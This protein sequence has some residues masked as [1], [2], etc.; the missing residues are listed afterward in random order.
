[1]KN[2]LFYIILA[3]FCL[4]ITGGVSAEDTIVYFYEDFE[5]GIGDDWSQEYV[6]GNIDWYSLNGGY[7]T[8]TS[9][10]GGGNPPFA[11]E[12]N[13]NAL[14][15]YTSLNQE[16]TRLVTPPIALD[17]AISPELHFMHAQEKLQILGEQSDKLRVLI[18]TGAEGDWHLLDEYVDPTTE[19]VFRKILIPDSLLSQ[20]NF[21][22]FEA[23]TRN[24]WGVCIDTLEIVEK[25]IRER[26]VDTVIA[27]QA[28]R[29]EVP[30]GTNNNP[31]LRIDIKVEG[32]FGDI[33]LNS[34]TINTLDTKAGNIKPGGVKLYATNKPTFSINNPLGSPQNMQQY[35]T[36]NN[37]NHTLKTGYN[38]IYVTY[39]VRD[40]AIQSDTLDAMLDYHSMDINSLMYP[41]VNHNPKG[42]RI[43]FETMFWDDFETD[44][45]WT[46]TG[47]FER[48]TAR[49][50]GGSIG[51]P[52]PET[53]YSETYVLGTDLSGLGIHEGDYEDSL[54]AYE[55]RAIS[56]VIDCGDYK[57]I[58]LR[59]R[60]WLNV[61]LSDDA[62]IDVSTHNSENWE[63][64]WI[65]NGVITDDE[66]KKIDLDISHIADRAKDIRIRFSIGP[67]DA[68]WAFSGWNIDDLFV[69]GDFVYKDIALREIITPKSGTD[70]TSS[71]QVK[72]KLE[73]IGVGDVTEN[74]SIQYILK[75]QDGNEY[76]TTEQISS[77]LN[78][79]DSLTYVFSQNL[80][81]SQP[82]YYE[83]TIIHHLSTDEYNI[84]DTLVNNI[85]VIPTMDVPYVDYFED[86]NN[87]WFVNGFEQYIK[88]EKQRSSW[89]WGKPDAFLI[90]HAA[91]DSNAW[92]TNLDGYYLQN[93]TSYIETP[94]F[95]FT[96]INNPYFEMKI[97]VST[98][99]NYDGAKLLY[100][101]DEG[102]TWKTV[103]ENASN[104]YGWDWYNDGIVS[105][106]GT[107]GWWDTTFT[108]EW[109]TVQQFLSDEIK[110]SKCKFRILFASGPEF[111]FDE[112]F[113]FDDVI[114]S[115]APPDLGVA[116]V[117]FPDDTCELSQEQTVS[118]KIKNEGIQVL[119]S[120]QTLRTGIFLQDSLYAID[121]FVTNSSVPVNGTFNYTF[122]RIFNM[123]DSGTY[124]L[125]TYVWHER[126][127]NVYGND[128]DTLTHSVNVVKPDVE[129]G[130]TLYTFR[131]D[132][133]TLF[134]STNSAYNFQWSDGSIAYYL[135][136]D[137]AG[138]YSVTVT[139]PVGG[140]SAVDTIEIV[141]L[142]ADIEIN[143]I[144]SPGSACILG[145]DVPVTVKITNTGI[146]KFYSG[147][148]FE[149][150]YK[151]NDEPAVQE[152]FAS[153][154]TLKPGD[155]LIY[156][157]SQHADFSEIKVHEMKAFIHYV[158]D[159]HPEND[160]VRSKINVAGPDFDL[161]PDDT[162]HWGF[163]Y[164]LNA[165][166]QNPGGIAFEWE[167]GSTDSIFEVT[168]RTPQYYTVTASEPGG[169]QIV[170]SAMV[171]LIIP[172]ISM[173]KM[174]TPSS[175]SCG[176]VSNDNVALALANTGT[177]VIDAGTP[178]PLN[179]KIKNETL[180][181]DDLEPVTD[182][183]PGDTLYFEFG[184]F[185]NLTD[186][187]PYEITSFVSWARDSLLS[188]D[189]IAKSIYIYEEANANITFEDTVINN[190]PTF[191]VDPGAFKTYKWHDGST[192]STFEV[193]ATNANPTTNVYVTVTNVDG[194]KDTDQAQV[195]LYF[196]DIELTEIEVP[197]TICGI[198]NTQPFKVKMTNKGTDILS[199]N[200]VQLTY[201]YGSEKK[202]DIF[203][204]SDL[205]GV[206]SVYYDESFSY[207]SGS[208]YAEQSGALDF[209]VIA[210]MTDDQVE[211]NDTLTKTIY[212]K[213]L[214]SIQW[215]VNS[216][217]INA[218]NGATYKTELPVELSVYGASSNDYVW[219]TGSNSQTINVDSK[220]GYAVTV[221]DY[222]NCSAGKTIF[223]EKSNSIY[224]MKNA[225]FTMNVYP[226]PTSEYIHYEI[227]SE[228]ETGYVFKIYQSNGTLIYYKEIDH[229]VDVEGSIPV[230][231]FNKGIYYMHV[232]G[233]D[234]TE[235][236]KIIIW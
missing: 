227:S 106:L 195:T 32:T 3:F 98:E 49:G 37:I 123:Y 182:F 132:T 167:D 193:N 146:D 236:R 68:A 60:R 34:V 85:F 107:K 108:S 73:N 210:H 31:I 84:N 179:Y 29:D 12:G 232:I 136:I 14:F 111:S 183:Y 192:N 187:K 21:I 27:Y 155:T 122:N 104:P 22:A 20:T 13:L 95:D 125:K 10:Q 41:A 117:L 170:D 160:T 45:G 231:H 127:H 105:A 225:G 178:I 128:N 138:T 103:Y 28:S 200:I 17:F 145:D 144:M 83:L 51:T 216:V 218:E 25:G 69:T 189:T 126:D 151:Q 61:D 154:D 171:K 81:L 211:E 46:L 92:V 198:S 65:N 50:L 230:G 186:Y 206:T 223:I 156:T 15:H 90:D 168:S 124:Y 196:S 113:A 16:T 181:T 56:P 52:D 80:D 118:I 26:F 162:N 97:W 39:D 194:C 208:V 1:M 55:Y 78:A 114:I 213:G 64:V 79:D 2:N 109:R 166:Y 112:G 110:D 43:I 139:D 38:Y 74:F 228:Q 100:S 142:L 57:D 53:A 93:D 6:K 190:K 91:S 129:L 163:T 71:E 30:T 94:Y 226:N 120:G 148:P 172:D 153:D 36:F 23:K 176:P 177:Y 184:E 67:S 35:V 201:L 173:V 18:K 134:A 9:V 75:D 224:D 5:E 8:D 152:A 58:Y 164:N 86:S 72:V 19:W 159:N 102:N 199:S 149:I 63:N 4:F 99:K 135:D 96:G 143:E 147:N 70:L 222:K 130:P 229:A 82:G 157:F 77:G 141:K 217:L 221:T 203:L 169:C 161:F 119:P 185:V 158:A 33:K 7:S 212:L 150:S 54:S 116:E 214:P 220:G 131:P 175:S 137:T 24:G 44:L 215:Q 42:R 47:E 205:D 11:Y 59:F 197:D 115:D 204:V 180:I 101:I 202:E 233:D 174:L 234:Y 87:F 235:V 188:N 133:V 140:C 66:W 40:D 219:N 88:D 191:D 121:T 76:T 165:G 89:E 48:D 62:K 207:T 209:T